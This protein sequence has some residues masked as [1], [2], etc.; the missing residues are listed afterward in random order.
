MKNGLTQYPSSPGV[1]AAAAR[2]ELFRARF[3]RALRSCVRRRF[4]VAECFGVIWEET[5]EEIALSEQDQAE[6]YEELIHWVDYRL[7]REL[8]HTH[9]LDLFTDNRAALTGFPG[10]L[11]RVVDGARPGRSA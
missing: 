2:R 7:F 1:G 10:G 4:S 5:I 8:M 11:T 9:S 6:L 3:Q